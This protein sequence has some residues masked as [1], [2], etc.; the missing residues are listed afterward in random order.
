MERP[1]KNEFL[2][3]GINA[4]QTLDAYDKYIDHLE[5]QIREERELLLKARDTLNEL[6]DWGS[7]ADPKINLIKEI[8]DNLK[9]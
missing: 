5:S 1:N 4:A 8:E 6:T 2:K 9:P 3:Y 7:G